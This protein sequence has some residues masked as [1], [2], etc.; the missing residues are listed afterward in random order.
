MKY[1]PSNVGISASAWPSLP[2]SPSLPPSLPSSLPPYLWV[3][4]GHGRHKSQE[5]LEGE[6]LLRGREGGRKSRVAAVAA[7]GR[8]K[9][10]S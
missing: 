6:T 2:L 9:T 1:V 7:A 3:P 5:I 4:L 10:T 8:G